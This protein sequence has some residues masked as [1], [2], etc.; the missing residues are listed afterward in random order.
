MPKKNSGNSEKKTL[1]KKKINTKHTML[2]LI[3]LDLWVSIL[4]CQS[5]DDWFRQGL[6]LLCKAMR[7]VLFSMN[8]DVLWIKEFQRHRVTM[9]VVAGPHCHE[10]IRWQRNELKLHRICETIFEKEKNVFITGGPGVGKSHLL[11]K[12][13]TRL[14][15][16]Y[17]SC[18]FS[19]CATTGAAAVLINAVTLHSFAGIG[20]KTLDDY[21]LNSIV[22]FTKDTTLEKWKKLKILVVDEISMLSPD[23]FMT[24]DAFAKRVRN[25]PGKAFG[26]VQLVLVGDFYQLAPVPKKENS[27]IVT[28]NGLEKKHK[29]DTVP[30][31]TA[32]KK[33]KLSDSRAAPVTPEAK[34][35]YC[36]ETSCW[37][38]AIDPRYCF[39]LDYVF[40]QSDRQFCSMLQNIRIGECNDFIYKKLYERV[41]TNMIPQVKDKDKAKQLLFENDPIK[42]IELHCLNKSADEI[43]VRHMNELLKDKNN[44]A[45]QMKAVTVF[46][47]REQCVEKDKEKLKTELFENTSIDKVFTLCIGAQVMLTANLSIEDGLINGSKGTIKGFKRRMF[48]GFLFFDPI[49][50][51]DNGEERAIMQSVWTYGYEQIKTPNG[52]RNPAISRIRFRN[53]FRKNAFETKTKQTKKKSKDAEENDTDDDDKEAKDDDDDDDDD[54]ESKSVQTLTKGEE[55]FCGISVLQYPLKLAWAISVHKSQGASLD[56]ALINIGQAFTYGQGLVA[57]SRLTSLEGM[58]LYSFHPSNIKTDPKVTLFYQVLDEQHKAI[59]KTKMQTLLLNRKK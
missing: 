55:S 56:K 37:R 8:L 40:R 30:D 48:E 53:G 20:T 24:L 9:K 6:H 54:S 31:T 38:A 36:F 18:E 43:N 49:V 42:P 45:K 57:L 35:V 19:V 22:K 16:K 23:F 5:M 50:T 4:E 51:F 46:T 25:E 28:A 29:T 17:D 34:P 39:I 13:V 47:K 41:I 27:T 14:E 44:T 21:T 7:A 1:N 58:Y 12:I 59:A 3:P 33:Q 2:P 11:K 10:Y 32:T 52:Y 26:G 15:Q